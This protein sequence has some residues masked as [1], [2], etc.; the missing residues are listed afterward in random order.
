MVAVCQFESAHRASP[1]IVTDSEI[2][3][4][5]PLLLLLGGRTCETCQNAAA[6]ARLIRA[7]LDLADD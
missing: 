5:G 6:L 4:V 1:A 7:R 3:S 2:L